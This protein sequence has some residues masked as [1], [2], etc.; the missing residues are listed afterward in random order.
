MY[1]ISRT[2]IGKTTIFIALCG[3]FFRKKIK[4]NINKYLFMLFCSNFFCFVG[5]VQ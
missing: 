3:H 4:K 5:D 1:K 2:K